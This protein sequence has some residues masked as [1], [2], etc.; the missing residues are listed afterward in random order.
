MHRDMT[1][2]GRGGGGHGCDSLCVISDVLLESNKLL[3]D[4]VSLA[5]E[6]G[7]FTLGLLVTTP[8]ASAL[9]ILVQLGIQQYTKL[10]FQHKGLCRA[11]GSALL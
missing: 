9:F 8:T 4:S 5:S 2:Q 3:H 10:L 1:G 7:T 11:A 6:P